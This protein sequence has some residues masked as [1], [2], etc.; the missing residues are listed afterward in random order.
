MTKELRAGLEAVLAHAVPAAIGER[1]RRLKPLPKGEAYLVRQGEIVYAD[2]SRPAPGRFICFIPDPKRQAFTVELGWSADGQFPATTA[3]PSTGP[4]LA[5][6]EGRPRG[7]VRLSELYTRLGTDWDLLPFDDQDPDWF[8]RVMAFEL[9]DFGPE[10]ATSL[11]RPLVEDA[12]R[13]LEQY[14][15]AFFDALEAAQRA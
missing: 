4:E 2:T 12:L 10:E 9:R 15:P 1:Y 3:R 11:V 5:I 6:R 13:K 8:E 14:A 7:F